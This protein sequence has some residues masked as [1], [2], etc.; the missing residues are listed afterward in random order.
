MGATSGGKYFWYVSVGPTEVGVFVGD[1][2]H[3]PWNDPLG[4]A[5]L[6]DSLGKSLQPPTQIRDPSAFREDNGTHYIVFGTFEYYIARL[7]SDMISL[8]EAPR[9]ITIINAF[10]QNGPNKTDDKPF[11]HKFN[12]RYYLSWG[13]F[14]GMGTS[15]YGPFTYQATFLDPARIAPEFQVHGGPTNPWYRQWIY[16]DRHGSFFEFHNQW[17][18]SSNDLSHSKASPDPNR[19][20][21]SILTYVHFRNNGSIAP[22][23]IDGTGV[24]EYDAASGPI[25]AENYFKLKGGFKHEIAN[26][27]FE[28]AGLADG[29]SVVFPNIR[30]VPLQ[31]KL[32]LRLS[33]IEGAGLV[34]VEADGVMVTSAALPSTGAW[35]RYVTL[36]LPLKQM[37]PEVNLTLVFIS[38]SGN[39]RE[40]ARLDSISFLNGG[41]VALI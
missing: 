27:G 12:G 20:R 2:P 24:G 19:F 28:I 3:G 37:Q 7:N 36:S 16:K 5:L 38:S 18:F 29:S 13:A 14:Y 6:S 40:L 11:L 1:S 41:V 4:K 22:L 26:G 32:S 8:A 9:H 17:Y 31:A 10:G 39:K 25:Q 34:R 33:S 23:A 35:N 15:P 21:D 30:N